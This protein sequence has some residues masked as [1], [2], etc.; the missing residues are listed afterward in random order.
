MASGAEVK[1]L[2]PSVEGRWVYT[3][4]GF[5]QST[6]PF[7]WIYDAEKTL[8]VG[9][10]FEDPK[11]PGQSAEYK[12]YDHFN[13][14]SFPVTNL[15]PFAPPPPGVTPPTVQPNGPGGLIGTN[16]PISGFFPYAESGCIDLKDDGTLKGKIWFTTAG[17]SSFSTPIAVTGRFRFNNGTLN[18]NVPPLSPP[19]VAGM[20]FAFDPFG[21]TGTHFNWDYAFVMVSN[22]EAQII[23]TGRYPRPATASGTMKRADWD[24]IV[25]VRP[26]TERRK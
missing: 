3:I 12:K 21:A 18:V 10:A 22:N 4:Q 13:L 11:N 23:T 15:L 9:W 24:S 20:S 2:D 6:N 16:P 7:T 26:R 25:P 8:E 14:L 5:M 1:S 17:C 19:P